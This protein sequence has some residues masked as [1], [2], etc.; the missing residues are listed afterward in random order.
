[1]R[2]KSILIVDDEHDIQNM[3]ESFL[4]EL[5]YNVSLATNGQQALQCFSETHPDIVLLDVKLP[6]ISG[7]EVLQKI[8]KAN[9]STSVIM[10]SGH[11]SIDLSN[12]TL[13]MGAFDYVAKP[14]NLHHLEELINIA[15]LVSD[16]D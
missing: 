15:E 1:M 9:P 16:G 5:D 14:L 13:E 7:I 11:S 8:K 6:E 2:K 10:L 12:Q 3:L 4:T